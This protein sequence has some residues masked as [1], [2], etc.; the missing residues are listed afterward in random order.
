MRYRLLVTD[1]ESG[2]PRPVDAIP[3]E[4]IEK[5]G[6]YMLWTALQSQADVLVIAA[7]REL[8]DLDYEL[9]VQERSESDDTYQILS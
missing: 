8:E 2:F 9:E 4:V 6:V 3:S 1:V 5:C 7:V